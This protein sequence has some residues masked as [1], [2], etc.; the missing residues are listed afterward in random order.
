MGLRCGGRCQSLVLVRLAEC[1]VTVRF[2]HRGEQYLP[3]GL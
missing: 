3:L 1:V 2:R